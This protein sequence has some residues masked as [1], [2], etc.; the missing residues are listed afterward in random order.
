MTRAL[1]RHLEPR[2][3][4]HQRQTLSMDNRYFHVRFDRDKYLT[5]GPST[6]FLGHRF[7]PPG[8]PRDGI[9][10]SWKWDGAQLSIE[11]DRYGV[12][13]LYYFVRKNEICIS[14]SL[15]TLIDRGAPSDLNCEALAVFFRLGYFLGESTPFRAIRALPPNVQFTWNKDGVNCVTEYP[16]LSNNI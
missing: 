13:P 16:L 9:F 6:C 2:G 8:A 3:L 15:P 14:S 1:Q 10:S 12:Y 4:L 5:S 7:E 11:N